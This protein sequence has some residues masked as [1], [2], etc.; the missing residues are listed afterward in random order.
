[1]QHGQQAGHGAGGNRPPAPARGTAGGVQCPLNPVIH[2]VVP[3]NIPNTDGAANGAAG[4]N[5]VELEG[6][7]IYLAAYT[8]LTLEDPEEWDREANL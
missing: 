1:M 8:D 4:Q 7:Q 2:P 3:A 5:Q 6:L